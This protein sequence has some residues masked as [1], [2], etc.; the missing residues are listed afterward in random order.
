MYYYKCFSRHDHSFQCSV[1]RAHGKK[2]KI[3]SNGFRHKNECHDQKTRVPTIFNVVV[4]K[5]NFVCS[6][7]LLNGAIKK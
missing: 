5:V 3:H 1:I 6:F 7:W 2:K 4:V